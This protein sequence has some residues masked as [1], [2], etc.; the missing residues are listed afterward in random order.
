MA[1]TVSFSGQI[2]LK[3]AVTPADPW[4][5]TGSYTLGPNG[6]SITIPADVDMCYTADM[7]LA[8][9]SGKNYEP[10]THTFDSTAIDDPD[11]NAVAV[12][13]LYAI[14]LYNTHATLSATFVATNMGSVGWAG[15]LQPGAYAVMHYPAGLTVGATAQIALTGL[16]GT[17]TIRAIVFG[18]AS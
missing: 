6:Q 16:S 9:G 2:T 7:V 10:D 5:G 12:D 8:S 1:M 3:G 13:T 14:V 17:P 11:G 15:T 4:A 18:R